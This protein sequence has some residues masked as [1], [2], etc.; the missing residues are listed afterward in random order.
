ME[1]NGKTWR[2]FD[3]EKDHNCHIYHITISLA[4][5]PFKISKITKE[6]LKIPFMLLAFFSL[7]GTKMHCFFLRFH[8][9]DNYAATCY[10]NQP[11]T[12]VDGRL[13]LRIIQEPPKEIH[14]IV[15]RCASHIVKL[16]LY[17]ISV[18]SSSW[19]LL[20]LVSLNM[21]SWPHG[22]WLGRE[23]LSDE[24]KHIILHPNFFI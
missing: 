15:R 19:R 16:I 23:K 14:P 12:K 22:L 18:F 13:N 7:P 6:S 4:C 3:Q 21:T 9:V 20:L 2:K 10:D 24:G 1:N 17:I 5:N 8:W 11:K